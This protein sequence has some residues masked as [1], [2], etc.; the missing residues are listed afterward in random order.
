VVLVP[1]L[2]GLLGAY[3]GDQFTQYCLLGAAAS[4]LAFM[5]GRLGILSLGHAVP[6]GIGAYAMGSA[7]LHWRGSGVLVGLVL[8][9]AVAGLVSFAIAAVGLRGR[10]EVVP[11]ALVTFT[12]V[13]AAGQLVNTLTSVTGGFD[14]LNDVPRLHLGAGAL[15][16]GSQRVVTA[17]LVAVLLLVLSR[18][19]RSPFGG[20]LTMIRDVPRRAAAL[21]YHV[22]LVR[23]AVFT[24]AG[25]VTGLLGAL[26]ATQAGS[27]TGNDVSVALATNLVVYALLGSRT[28]VLGPFA[29]SVAVDF[30]GNELADRLLDYW[31][32][33]TGAVFVLAVL[34]APDGIA[35]LLSRIWVRVVPARWRPVT[36]VELGATPSDDSEET[37]RAPLSATGET[38]LSAQGVTCRFGPFVAVDSADLDIRA[39]RVH[40]L[41]GP[42]GAGKST[43]LD[44]LSGLHPRSGG[45]R[46]LHG[47]LDLTR[48][49][50][51]T[52]ARAGVRRKF[53]APAVAPALTVGQNLVLAGHRQHGLGWFLGSRWRAEVTEECSAI[54]RA[55]GLDDHLDTPASDLSHGQRQLL[56]LAMTVAKRPRVVVLDEP[57]AGLSPAE[58]ALVGTALRRLRDEHAL[59]IVMVEH[60]IELVRDLADDV[61][62]LQGGRV[63]VTGDMAAVSADETVRAAYLGAHA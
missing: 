2:A 26:M 4:V 34:V 57:T 24:A 63:L 22:P 18:L 44:V 61:T 45:R 1:V 14:G 15:T 41:I 8:A 10:V 37:G 58:T 5:W 55:G 31:L 6:F 59:P 35:T 12:V 7:A 46:E 23:I 28:S 9:V 20:L 29:V 30:A 51:W 62:V 11:F 25:A 27:V 17:S 19:S 3:R 13:M 21:G 16:P 52:I 42:N 40:C 47:L 39:G 54:L 60:D 53:Q 48:A 32:L 49:R 38:V 56:D 50:P 33:G 36:R 43:L